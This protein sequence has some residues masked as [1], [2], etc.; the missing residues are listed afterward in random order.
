MC[1]CLYASCATAA[2]CLEGFNKEVK[3]CMEGLSFSKES[4]TSYE[5]K[6]ELTYTDVIKSTKSRE[7]G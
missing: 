1:L 6:V 7:G 2:Q 3:G 5:E 4:I